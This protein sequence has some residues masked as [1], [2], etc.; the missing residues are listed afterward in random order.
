MSETMMMDAVADIH[1][2]YVLEFADVQPVAKVGLMRWMLPAAACLCLVLGALALRFVDG[3]KEPPAL[4]L[5]P[6][7]GSTQSQIP[8]QETTQ[9]P[10]A[11]GPVSGGIGDGSAVWG[12]KTIWSGSLLEENSL[13]LN[14]GTSGTEAKPNMVT[15]LP[16]L[17]KA[18]Q[19][20]TE[21]E[22]LFAVRVLDALGTDY[23]DVFRQ[24]AD[25]LTMVREPEGE[26]LFLTGAQIASIQCPEGM[27]L[28]I[29]L[30][31]RTRIS[32]ITL[33]VLSQMEQDTLMVDVWFDFKNSEYYYDAYDNG[34]FAS[35]EE[36][37]A[38]RTSEMLRLTG[39]HLA[40]LGL[41]LEDARPNASVY[42]YGFT[43]ELTR[44][45]MARLL[46]EEQF[47]DLWRLEESY[48]DDFYEEICD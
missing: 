24:I 47:D 4:E 13:S 46:T 30:A 44:E 3:P 17:K 33:D 34:I 16:L 8:T 15:I 5:P 36:M 19:A 2:R 9:M 37:R 27:A 12:G 35:M 25:T 22:T 18:L 43:A 7:A 1:D 6:V 32:N 10:T 42:I 48:G 40:A 20:Y 14:A 45:Q 11:S 28:R 26:I 31:R 38:A 21:P 39:E 41:A 29:G 23:K